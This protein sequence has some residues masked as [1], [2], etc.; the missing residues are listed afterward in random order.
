MDVQNGN[1]EQK[2][3]KRKLER[4]IEEE[5]GDDYILDLKK[6]YD[7]DENERYDIVPE[8]WEGRNVADFVDP[9]IE[10][11]LLALEREEEERINSGY[12]DFNLDSEDDE[13]KEIRGLAK[14]IREKK[15]IMK[16]E[17]RMKQTNKPK[18]PRN[19]AKRVSLKFCI[20]STSFET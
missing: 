17:Q 1:G 14:Q 20:L 2:S 18:M 15:G 5:L 9:D 10:S 6:N 13:L 4:D 3:L 8:I 7:I 12:Y 19:V 16:F 11:K